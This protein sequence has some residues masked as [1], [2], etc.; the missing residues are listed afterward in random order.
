M[1]Y[2]L[3]YGTSTLPV[4]IPDEIA[5]DL[6]EAPELPASP[7]PG[8][9]V[10]N[11]LDNL[12][13]TLD[14]GDFAGVKSVGIA[15]NDK[16]R[17]VPHDC[18]LPPLLDRLKTL[19][20]PLEAVTLF[21]A[22]GTHPPMSMDEFHTILPDAVLGSY[23]VVSHDAEARDKLVYLGDTTHG[24]PVWLNSEFLQSELKIVIGNIEPHQFV[25][26]SG[27]VKS[28]AIGL[29]GMATI[30]KNHALMT[31]PDSLV[32]KYDSNPA[33]Q[34]IE[35]IGRVIGIHLALNAILNQDR[36]IVDVLAGDPLAVMKAGYPRSRRVCQAAVTGK[37]ALVIASPGGHPKD[38]NV[39]QSQKGLAHAALVTQLGGTILLAAACPEG[40]GSP[41]YQDWMLGKKSYAE[42]IQDFKAEGFQV[43]PHKAFLIARVASRMNV[44][45]YSE[46]DETLA[47]DLLLN[48]VQDFQAVVNHGLKNLGPGERVGWMPHAVSTIPFS[49]NA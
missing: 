34:D 21:I 16:T 32:G 43:G 39:Y 49:T 28:A 30:N 5:V 17:P 14:W 13:G 35:E 27:G 18:L 20:I 36:Q 38:I 48:P 33:R 12:L 44:R 4:R 8:Y 37:Y 42:V 22:V 9:L 6:I 19:G 3:P 25:G 26:F 40:S 7:D 24:T 45:F 10:R 41:H 15:I 1:I 11:A 46:M 23:R 47:H 31:H 2:H 29:A